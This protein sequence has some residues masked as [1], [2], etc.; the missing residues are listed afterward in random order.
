MSYDSALSVLP[1]KNYYH[2]RK[3]KMSM[4]KGYSSR[5]LFGHINNYDEKR[6]VKFKSGLAVDVEVLDIRTL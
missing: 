4:K 3:R 2:L 1:V 6:T 5:G